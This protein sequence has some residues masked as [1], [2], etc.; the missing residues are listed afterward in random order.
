[1]SKTRKF[2]TILTMVAVTTT[3]SLTAVSSAQASHRHHHRSGAVA[4][5][6]LSGLVVGGIIANS[7]RRPEVYARPAGQSDHVNWCYRRYRS[8]NARTDTYTG[9]DGRQHYCNSPYVY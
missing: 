1:M 3:I 8:Y 7:S 6:V 9:Y 4:L 5:G 2:L